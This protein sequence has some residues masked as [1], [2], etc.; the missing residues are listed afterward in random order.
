MVTMINSEYHS[1]LR[2]HYAT[3]FGELLGEHAPT[4]GPIHELP[5]GFVILQFKKGESKFV[6][7]TAG[8]APARTPPIELH[9][10][11][12][13]IE[14]SRPVELLSVTA[15]FHTT[16]R[17]LDLGHTVNFGEP[18]VSG[19]PSDHALVSLPYPF[20]ADLENFDHGELSVGCYWLLPITEPERDLKKREGLDT[21]EERLDS[22]GIP[23]WDMRRG[24][25]V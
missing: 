2:A 11:A 7:A 12:T 22:A 24:S 9:L 19:S 17:A 20:G 16:G 6:F 8:M 5:S 23:A 13:E 1:G 18:C 4:K 3:H 25:A 15:H 14:P 21:L 10:L